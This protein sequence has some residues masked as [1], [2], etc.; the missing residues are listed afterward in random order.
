M[1][2]VT[3]NETNS[4]YPGDIFIQFLHKLSN[5]FSHDTFCAENSLKQP[6][7]ILLKKH[8][9][10]CV[11]HFYVIHTNSHQIDYMLTGIHQNM[12]KLQ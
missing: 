1:Y 11:T 4:K 7:L 6:G 5:N 3:D 2:F 12:S 10:L 9:V 8:L